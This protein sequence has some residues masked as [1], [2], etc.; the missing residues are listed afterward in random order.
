MLDPHERY[1]H[2]VERMIKMEASLDTMQN[3]HLRHIESSLAN[4]ERRFEKQ[5][6]KLWGVIVVLLVATIS[7]A[8][9]LI[10]GVL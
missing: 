7:T 2:L 5:D 6:T 4:M 1:E 3:N 10:G 8:F 9:A